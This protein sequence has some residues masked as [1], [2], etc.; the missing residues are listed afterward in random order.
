MII[1]D[2]SNVQCCEMRLIDVNPVQFR[3]IKHLTSTAKKISISYH[4]LTPF[5]TLVDSSRLEDFRSYNYINGY[6]KQR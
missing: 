4:N 6:K 1:C 3:K 5:I 2:W